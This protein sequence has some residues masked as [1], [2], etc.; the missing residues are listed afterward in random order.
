LGLTLSTEFQKN[1]KSDKIVNN[2]LGKWYTAKVRD[3]RNAQA[4]GG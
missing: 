4:G 2:L 1:S 3:R